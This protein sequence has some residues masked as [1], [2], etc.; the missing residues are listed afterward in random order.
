MIVKHK[1]E[2]W[3]IISHYAHGLLSGKIAQELK[4]NLRPAHWVDILTGIIEHDDHLLDFDEQEYLTENGTPKDFTMEGGSDRE[5]LEHAKRVYANAMQKSQLVALM[6]GRHLNFLY[7]SLSK[8][9]SP[10]K[11]FL[12][13]LVELRT[14]QRKL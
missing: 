13:E 11:K 10:M 7:D 6:V 3:E 9:Y 8:E 14:S 1:E 5:A 12:E 2:G 4:I